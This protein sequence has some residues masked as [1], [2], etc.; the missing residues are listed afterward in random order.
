MSS[1]PTIVQCPVCDGLKK[2]RRIDLAAQNPFS[3]IK[4]SPKYDLHPSEQ[5]VTCTQCQGQG[6]VVSQNGILSLYRGL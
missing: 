2:L 3:Q 4:G 5:T 6:V 1:T